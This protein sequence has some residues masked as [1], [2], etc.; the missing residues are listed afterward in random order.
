MQSLTL[1]LVSFT[2]QSRGRVATEV[3]IFSKSSLNSVFMY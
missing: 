1:E 2:A 3:C